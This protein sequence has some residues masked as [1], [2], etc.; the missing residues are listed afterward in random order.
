MRLFC[1]GVTGVSALVLSASAAQ[2]AIM[3][4]FTGMDLVYDGSSFF[5]GGSSSGGMADPADGDS[6][7]SVDFFDNGL[8]VGSLSSDIALDFFIPDIGSIPSAPNTTYNVTTPGN[9][10]YFDLLMGTTPLASEFLLLDIMSVSVTYVDVGGV[11]EF[12]F[13]GAISPTIA[14][15]LPFGLDVAQPV[16]LS[17]SAQVT[18]GTIASS[19]GFI[20]GFNAFGTGEFYGVPAPGAAGVLALAG[21]AGLRRRRA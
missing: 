11:A 8:P 13:A 10:G 9:A 21:L 5:D 19:G 4:E 6:L 15:N 2:S 20:T 1:H 7:V 3:I 16:T 17:F 18:P 12:V 14:Q